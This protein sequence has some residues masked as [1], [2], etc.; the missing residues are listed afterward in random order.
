M[1]FLE[2]IESHSFELIVYFFLGMFF[3][4][5]IKAPLSQIRVSLVSALGAGQIIFFA[6]IGATENKVRIFH[7]RNDYLFGSEAACMTG[8][9]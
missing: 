8:A 6:G 7:P 3:F 9:L 5:D 2:S 4:R 1:Y